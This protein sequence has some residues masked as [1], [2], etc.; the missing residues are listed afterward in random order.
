MVLE[1]YPPPDNK[2]Q[3]VTE[4]P[5][6][7][8]IASTIRNQPWQGIT[9]AVL[10]IDKENWFEISGSLKSEDGLSASYAENGKEF[11]STRPPKSLAEATALMLSY[12]RGDGR[13]R[14]DIGWK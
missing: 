5:D 12:H 7:K 3:I 4:S 2:R 6:E 10:R 13:W 11:V 14:K 8:S 1:V 9:F